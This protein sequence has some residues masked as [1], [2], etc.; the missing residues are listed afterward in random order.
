MFVYNLYNNNNNYNRRTEFIPELPPTVVIY[1]A[2][3]YMYIY[4]IY[5]FRKLEYFFLF[6][7][8]RVRIAANKTLFEHGVYS[9]FYIGCAF[10]PTENFVFAY[11]DAIN[12]RAKREP[13]CERPPGSFGRGGDIFIMFFF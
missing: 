11:K 7:P 10:R 8:L 5:I 4:Y 6:N 3:S 12:R 1:N 13:L 9:V 2:V